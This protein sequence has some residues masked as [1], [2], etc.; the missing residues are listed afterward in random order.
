M[1][2]FDKII[3]IYNITN[4]IIMNW[5]TTGNYYVSKTFGKDTND[6]SAN[7]PFATMRK[8]MK[9]IYDAGNNDGS[10]LVLEGGVVY[11]ENIV[12]DSVGGD[13]YN[14]KLRRSIIFIV[15]GCKATIKSDNYNMYFGTIAGEGGIPK[16][17]ILEN[18]H[19]PYR[20]PSF[21]GYVNLYYDYNLIFRNCTF[22]NLP[23][24]NSENVGFTL[25]K[26]TVNEIEYFGTNASKIKIFSSIVIN[27]I[28]RGNLTYTSIN[29]HIQNLP[30][31]VSGTMIL[32]TGAYN[33]VPTGHILQ[34]LSHTIIGQD[35]L[36]IDVVNNNFNLQGNSPLLNSG[37]PNELTGKPSNIGGTY[38]ARSQ[39]G[40]DQSLTLNNIIIDGD[41]SFLLDGSANSGTIESGIIDFGMIKS[42]VK[43]DFISIFDYNSNGIPTS[44]ID[45]SNTIAIG[46]AQSATTS[47]MVLSA[48]EILSSTNG[49]YNGMYVKIT[50]GTGIGELHEIIGYNASTKTI[51]ITDTFSIV[52]NNTS[53]YLIVDKNRILFD[54]QVRWSQLNSNIS[55]MIGYRQ[56]ELCDYLTYSDIINK[57]GN[58]EPQYVYSERNYVSARYLQYKITL[59]RII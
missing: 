29:S 9:A 36:F 28:Q 37:I 5:K 13:G 46:T 3:L 23:V 38:M 55:D 16:N 26:C 44:F 20:T 32:G 42:V 31:L 25:D 14:P 58:A 17:D 19:F 24:M 56:M 39:N 21:Q 2:F 47:S 52:P 41:G 59:K 11:N 27:I 45:F 48:T 57:Y 50:G 30:T 10:I 34:T 35:P 22:I 12:G 53:Q 4:L 7:T 1:L 51:N 33:S 40:F 6:G 43:F 8:G 49:Y 18:F 15:E 54:F